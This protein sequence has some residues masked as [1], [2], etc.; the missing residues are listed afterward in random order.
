MRTIGLTLWFKNFLATGVNNLL[1][2][3]DKEMIENIMKK[4]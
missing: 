4:N 1:R 2:E 3:M